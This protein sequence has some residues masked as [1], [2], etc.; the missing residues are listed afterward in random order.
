[1]IQI[2]TLNHITYDAI[3]NFGF[4][5]FITDSI[6]IISQENTELGFSFNIEKR[7]LDNT[8]VKEWQTSKESVEGDNETLKY[9]LSFGAYEG[10]TLV[11]ILLVSKV[12]WNN[13]LWIEN[14]RVTDSHRGLGIA[15]KMLYALE[16]MGRDAG[17]RLIGLEVMASN[18]PA[19]ELYKKYGYK[20]D[21]LDT[22]HY[23]TRQGGQ[24]EVALF[25]K[26]Y[27]SDLI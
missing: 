6:Y 16:N 14:I 3:K 9:G 5:G 15:Q 4:N 27:L 19:I 2:R 10:E 23:P 22:S 24:K 12:S 11:G 8:Y 18:Y 13:S 20:I 26:Y 1:M 25:M 17:Y 7:K 21:G